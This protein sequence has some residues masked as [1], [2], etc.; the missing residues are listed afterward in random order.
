MENKTL[1][2]L[3]GL[4]LAAV[5]LV[6]GFVGKVVTDDAPTKIEDPIDVK[7]QPAQYEFMIK[8]V[9]DLE[10]ATEAQKL[11]Q[12]GWGLVFARRAKDGEGDYAYECIFQRQ[13]RVPDL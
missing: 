1:T 10:W 11:G 13:S 3:T 9:P 12:E 8:S 7:V 4:N 6:A 5:L 2:I